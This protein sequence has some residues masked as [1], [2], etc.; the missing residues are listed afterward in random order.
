VIQQGVPRVGARHSESFVLASEWQ[1]SE[2]VEV[3]ARHTGQVRVADAPPVAA[4][5]DEEQ[6]AHG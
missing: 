3:I 4:G 6:P 5:R 2:H 1:E